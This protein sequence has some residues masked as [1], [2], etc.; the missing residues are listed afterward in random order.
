MS[1]ESDAEAGVSSD[2]VCVVGNGPSLALADRTVLDTLPWVGMNAAYRDWSETGRYPTYYACLDLIVGA[3]HAE[4]IRELVERA[5][6]FGI[7]SFLLRDNIR[8]RLS[9]AR[10]MDRVQFHENLPQGHLVAG[11]EPV[12]TGSHA[13]LWMASLGYRRLV[14]MG[15]D[16][17]YVEKVPAATKGRGL[18][19]QIEAEAPN[20]NYYFDNYQKPG[21]R[22]SVPNPRPGTHA[23]AW[24][25][26]AQKSLDGG[27]DILN[28]S[29]GSKLFQFPAVRIKRQDGETDVELD[30]APPI[31]AGSYSFQTS[32]IADVLARIVPA[33]YGRI[34][35]LEATEQ[36]EFS[37]RG[38]IC[39]GKVGGWDDVRWDIVVAEDGLPDAVEKA[40]GVLLKGELANDPIVR[41]HLMAI[42]D[43]VLMLK[44]TDGGWVVSPMSVDDQDTDYILTLREYFVAP[45]SQAGIM[46]ERE[47]VNHWRRR[48]RSMRTRL[49]RR[50]RRIVG[51]STDR[52]NA[53]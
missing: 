18:Q 41:R 4:A 31:R 33:F 14:L 2:T 3:S 7:R 19:M 53:S 25:R 35:G 9:G 43:T 22:F 48:I 45:P 10:N 17:R 46:W 32:V 52:Q 44:Q 36:A 1:V 37:E 26:V 50:L 28:A 27:F 51:I 23:L 49:T 34:W 6:E 24:H 12:T 11:V 8:D 30:T 42:S 39:G 40:G 15:I 21:D 20:P 13:A 38:F 5:E 16:A 47:A 29:E